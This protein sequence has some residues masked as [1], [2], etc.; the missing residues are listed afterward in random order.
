MIVGI[1]TDLHGKSCDYIV[2]YEKVLEFNNIRSVRLDINQTDFWEKI[3]ELDLFIFRW[4]HIDD[5]R[6]LAHTI[7]P[8]IERNLGIKCFPDLNTSWHFDDKIRQY[9]LLSQF[10]FP[11]IKSW[12]FW[13]KVEA[14]NWSKTAVYPT[15][16]KLKGGAGSTNVLLIHNKAKAIRLINKMFWQG[17]YSERIPDSG[18]TQWKYFTV[19]NKLREWKHFMLNKINKIDITPYWQINK[20][21]VLFQEF[22]PDN[23][24]D[25]R[26][27]VIGKRAFAFRRFNR[28]NDFRSS[29]SGKLDYDIAKIDL[30][31]IAM[32]FEV[33]TAM[34]FQS[35]AYDFLY[36]REGKPVFCEISYTFVDS[37][38]RNCPGFWDPDLKWNEGHYWP[39]F[40][41]LS[42]LLNITDLKQPSFED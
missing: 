6:Q 15:V 5:H 34:K 14:I 8:V 21:Y 35:M 13:D 27:T 18:S 39:Q 3:K 11:M 32:A 4:Q 26:V 31:F 16:F 1:H 38:V 41:Q 42:D 29:G 20:N 7:L 12:I 22:M 9:Y 17:V 40:C 36:N 30:K 33:S 28:E 25:T 2:K 19:Y 37:A 10:G 24:Y 23:Q